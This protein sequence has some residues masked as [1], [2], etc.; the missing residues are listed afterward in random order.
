MYPKSS[1]WRRKGGGGG[2]GGTEA[3][4]KPQGPQQLYE[5]RALQD[6]GPPHSPRPNPADGLD[7]ETGPE[8]CIPSGP[9][10]QG[11]PRPPSIPMGTQVVPIRVS[12]I[13]AD[14]SSP[15]IHKNNET[16]GGDATAVGNSSDYISRRYLNYAPIQGTTHI[17]HSLCVPNLPGRGPDGQQGEISAHCPT[18]DRVPGIP[19]ELGFPTL[20][21]PSRKDEEDTAGCSNPHQPAGSLNKR[22]SQIRREGLSLSKSHLV[23]TPA[24]QGPTEYDTF[25]NWGGSIP[26]EQDVQVQ[27]QTPAH[28]GSREGPTVVDITRQEFPDGITPTTSQAIHD[29]RVRCLQHGLGSTPR[30]N[31]DRGTVVKGRVPEPHQLPGAPYSIPSNPVLYEGELRHNYTTE[32]GQH[33]CGVLHKQDGWDSLPTTL[34]SSSDYMG[35]DSATEFIPSGR[36]SPRGTKYS[37][38]SGVQNCEG[39]VRLDAEPQYIQQNPVPDGALRDRPIR[40]PPHKTVTEVFQLKTRPRG[41]GDRCLQPGLVND[42][43]ICQTPMV[44]DT[45]MPVTGESSE[46]QI[47][48]DHPPLEYSTMVPNHPGTPGGLPAAT[49]LSRGSG[50]APIRPGIHN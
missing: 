8:G 48:H 16:S 11:A 23:S 17:A 20:N 19:S 5:D 21:L 10:S 24:L 6:G 7:G 32:V 46:G 22:P 50:Y 26:S 3:S 18:G 14:I 13:Q 4:D 37:S 9:N 40:F 41:R 42:A 49:T 27:R 15:G 1:W 12:P 28:P 38:R 2:G 39:Q 29:Y 36:T 31:P 43:G 35:M 34:Q 44:S 45:S 30:G 47:D 33:N 25:C